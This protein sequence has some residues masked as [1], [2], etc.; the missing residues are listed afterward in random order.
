MSNFYFFTD[1]TLLD[2]Q[3][4][5]QAFGPAGTSAGMDQFRVT[6]LHASSSTSV[7]AFAICDGVLCAQE[8]HQGTL[9]LILKPSQSPPFE[10]PVVSYFIYKGIA[11]TSLLNINNGNILDEDASGATDFTK[12]IAAEWKK[13]N[14]NDLAGSRAA[15]GL[16]RDASFI[17]ED[18]TSQI[19]IFTD[20]DPI[21]RLFS[22]PHK[23]VQLSTVS[24]GGLIGSFQSGC[25]FEV[26]LKRLGYKP[27]LAF[28]RSADN[29]ISVD[30]L[31]ADNNGAPWLPDDYAFFAHWHEK[32]Q[33]LAFMDPCAFFGSFVQ[34]KLY[35]RSGTSTHRIKG[36]DIYDNILKKFANR[37]IAWLDIRNNYGYS[38]NLFGLYDDTIRLVSHNDATQTNDQNFRSKSWPILKLQIADVPGSKRGALHRTKLCLP[39][40]LSTAPA[41]LVSK[42]FVKTLGS[43]RSRFK[44]PR[45]VPDVNNSQFYKP[46]RLAFPAT[47]E[48]GQTVFTASYTRINL[49]EKPHPV[50]QPT[51][52]LNFVGSEY[53]D[54]VFRPRDLL[55]DKDFAGDS[56]RFE[57]YPEEV[58]VDLEE[59]YGPTYAAFVGI[60]EDASYVTLFAFP[61]YFLPN[62][63]GPNGPR[64]LPSWT[65]ISTS[66]T[67]DF[68]SKLAGTFRSTTVTKKTIVSDTL[69]AQID[70]IIIKNAPTL[71]NNSVADRNS[72]GD[73]CF[74]VLDKSDSQLLD[75]QVQANAAMN[76]AFP[77]FLT[78]AASQVK[79]DTDNKVTYE[80][81]KLQAS[82]FGQPGAAKLQVQITA[83]DQRIFQNA[84]V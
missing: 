1:P 55:F 37:N 33:V 82:G 52:P 59:N 14:A 9:T 19:N 23:T 6:D 54:G 29:Q 46:I 28:A 79:R 39:I 78:V 26:I 69:S 16:D 65:D 10:S 74:I 76:L 15:L 43:E 5:A 66:G 2:A 11:K 40:G 42:G 71:S 64:A 81:K 32:E 36:S 34:A 24:A 61:S 20:N 44:A 25:G 41:M 51:T 18:G 45:L 49:Y 21:D 47:D 80:E 77:V 50:T 56:L 53:L 13:Q 67:T 4:A 22:Y 58:L 68:L 70:T 12:R 8:D 84:N 62:G 17:H 30:S 38:Y 60:A 63:K 57:I 83:L 72:I 75:S 3:D 31:A 7:P 27:T 73:F 35:K 48:G